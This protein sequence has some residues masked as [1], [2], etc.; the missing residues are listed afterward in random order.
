MFQLTVD[1]GRI[2]AKVQMVLKKSILKP[3]CL[4]TGYDK[5]GS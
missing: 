3:D 4:I 2:E 5:T 1:N